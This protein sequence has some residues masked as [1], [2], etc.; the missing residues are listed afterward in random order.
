L[1]IH[2]GE[3]Y[4]S[5]E[6]I[7]VI[8]VF[9]DRCCLCFSRLL[10]CAEGWLEF[11]LIDHGHAEFEVSATV[12]AVRR[13]PHCIDNGECVGHSRVA[14]EVKLIGGGRDVDVLARWRESKAR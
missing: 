8:V 4:V 7:L 13:I 14:D 5:Q 12:V 10:E 3:T 9:F 1:K 2:G 11:K 6:I